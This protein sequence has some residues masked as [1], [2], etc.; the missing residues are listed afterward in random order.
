MS[1]KFGW[2]IGGALTGWLLGAFSF[3]ANTTLDSATQTGIV[4][5]LSFIPAAGALLSVV[6]ISLYPLSET[7]MNEISR[8]LDDRRNSR[9][10]GAVPETQHAAGA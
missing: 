5:M 10:A 6:F 1:Q 8:E 7:K 2:T 9:L 4:S 3:Q